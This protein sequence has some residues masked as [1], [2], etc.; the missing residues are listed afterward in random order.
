MVTSL[1]TLCGQAF[2]AGQHHQVGVY[3]QRAMLVLAAEAG[4]Y[5]R[6]LTPALFVYGQMQCHVRF[7][8]TQNLVVP[9][10]SRTRSGVALANAVAYLV[11]LCVLALYVRLSPS[12]TATWDGFSGEAFCG[13]PSFLKLAVP[14]ALM[15]WL[16]TVA[17]ASMVP[18]GLGAAI[19]TRVSN[20][21]GAGRPHAARLAT[22]VV[23]FLAFSVCLSEGIALV[24]ARNILGYAYS[25]DEEVAR[26]AAR[27]MP[28]LAVAILIDGLQS[29]LSDWN[30]EVRMFGFNASKAKDRVFS[31]TPPISL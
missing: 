7:L 2:G 31:S 24:L 4:R 8:Q 20:E 21:L 23:M 3:K 22:R 30:R 12:C 16:H 11:N 15:L 13:I 19:S 10:P 9:V 5:I 27:V 18:L 1:E 29:I 17:L 6:W 26:Y 25:N 14:S 28:V